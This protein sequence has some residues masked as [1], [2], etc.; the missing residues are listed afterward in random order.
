MVK[1]EYEL[2]GS[3]PF[4]WGILSVF[5]SHLVDS[6][7]SKVLSG[8]HGN[9]V[10]TTIERWVGWRYPIGVWSRFGAHMSIVALLSTVETPLLSW[11][12]RDVWSCLQPLH[13]L[14]ASSR[15]LKIAS[16]FDHLALWSYIALFGWMGPLL[17]LLLDS[18]HDRVDLAVGSWWGYRCYVRA[19]LRIGTNVST[20]ILLSTIVALHVSWSSCHILVALGWCR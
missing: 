13:V 11:I 17:E 14:V 8:S 5:K 20:V 4:I 10:D 12:L 6:S 9:R 1:M 7:S 16:G 2:T 18:R 3:V 15:S 19:V